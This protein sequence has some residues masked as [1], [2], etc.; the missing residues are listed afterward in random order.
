MVRLKKSI[1][2]IYYFDLYLKL[3][4]KNSSELGIHLFGK[5]LMNLLM[6]NSYKSILFQIC[7]GSMTRKKVR[8]N[9]KKGTNCRLFHRARRETFSDYR[10]KRVIISSFYS[11]PNIIIV[12]IAKSYNVEYIPVK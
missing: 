8:V 12:A 4:K 3:A 6:I 9:D 5:R 1:L 2:K 11:R 7:C 10:G